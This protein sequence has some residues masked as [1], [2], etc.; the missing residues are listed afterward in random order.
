MIPE[1]PITLDEVKS[2]LTAKYPHLLTAEGQRVKTRLEEIFELKFQIYNVYVS[3]LCVC[4]I[5]GLVHKYCF[6]MSPFRAIE[7][8]FAQGRGAFASVG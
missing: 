3:Y 2:H 6:V 7:P 8:Q 5:P 4:C 1:L